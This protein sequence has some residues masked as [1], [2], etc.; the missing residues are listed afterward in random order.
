MVAGESDGSRV[1]GGEAYLAGWYVVV[2]AGCGHSGSLNVGGCVV[3][4]GVG[5]GH[6][7]SP[8]LWTKCDNGFDDLSSVSVIY[9]LSRWQVILNLVDS[10]N[11]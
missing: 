11:V 8:I 4:V 10:P 7:S 2:A 6:F 9:L 1:A 3:V 5:R